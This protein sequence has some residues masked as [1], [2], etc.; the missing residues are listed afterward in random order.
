MNGD[1]YIIE[2]IGSSKEINQKYLFYSLLNLEEEIS[3]LAKISENNIKYLTNEEIEKIYEMQIPIVP[4]EIQNEVVKIL[5][6][7]KNL[8]NLV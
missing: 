7:L 6:G 1:N 3:E 5:D 8:V 4:L 2:I